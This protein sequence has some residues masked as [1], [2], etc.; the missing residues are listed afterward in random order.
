MGYLASAPQAEDQCSVLSVPAEA[1]GIT[2]LHHHKH[3]IKLAL[4]P[5]MGKM[6]LRVT[7]LVERG[8]EFVLTHI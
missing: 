1:T 3:F 5:Q 6:G 7:E 2:S 8:I 4:V